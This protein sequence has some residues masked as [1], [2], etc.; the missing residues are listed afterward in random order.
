MAKAKIC[1][2]TQ[3]ILSC[4]QLLGSVVAE[5][6]SIVFRPATLCFNAISFL[7]NVPSK[8]GSVYEGIGELLN[9]V[10]Y[11]LVLRIYGN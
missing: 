1:D 7:L 5:S 4:I 6:T 3:K 10:R 2:D 11:T 9:E 8:I